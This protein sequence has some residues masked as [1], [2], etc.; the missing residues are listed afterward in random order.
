VERVV[1][2]NIAVTAHNI[3]DWDRDLAGDWSRGPALPDAGQVAKGLA[4]GDLAEPLGYDGIWVP[5]HFGSPYGMS[6]NPLQ[7]LAY[8]A[9]RTERIGFGTMVLVLPWWHPVRLA[10]QIAW[11]DIVSKGRFETI[12]LGR[13]VA[14]REFD[15]LA[16][17]REESRQRFAECLDIIELALTNEA[18]SYDG[19]I[20]QIPE[21]SLRPQPLTRD[22]PSR[23]YGA[24][25][26]NTSLEY[27]ARRGLKPLM[28]GNKPL[29][30]S[31]EDLKLVNRY[32]AEQ[33]L[34]STQ[35]K[36]VIFMYC[37]SDRSQIDKALG[38][39]DQAN[40]A[41]FNHYDFGNR[42]AFAGVKGYEAYAAGQANTTA[43]DAPKPKDEVDQV[44]NLDNMLIG[45][46]DE[47]IARIERQQ[48]A[49]SYC[50]IAIH[51]AL[52]GMDF[53]MAEKSLRLFAEEVL[54]VVH[55]MET[56]LHAS[57]VPEAVGQA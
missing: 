29:S 42:A 17:P 53:A 1:K 8:F 45:T 7:I 5:D 9:G 6:P 18:F 13:G 50:E 54:P 23:F 47:I 46:P 40:R 43:A 20:F 2:V 38:Y 21:T 48:Q 35:S 55:K 25:A 12:G 51:P 4:F 15:A 56:P 34:S 27:M 14:K 28:I 52:G 33:G 41:I 19:E 39:M 26:T 3:D 32:R 44:Y 10:H 22:L 36:N 11:L 24:S 31:A 49:S 30:E 37:S 57:A 16:V